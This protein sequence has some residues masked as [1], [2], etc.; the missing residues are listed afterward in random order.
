MDVSW[1]F[2][3]G[4]LSRPLGAAEKQQQ[5]QWYNQAAS[6]TAGPIRSTCWG[7]ELDHGLIRHPHH[8]T[9]SSNLKTIKA[10]YCFMLARRLIA[11]P[12]EA[13]G[14]KKALLHVFPVLQAFN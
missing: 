11:M 10:K 4:S 13:A 12:L 8:I 7:L 5:E 14:T 2:G 3:F 9:E 1:P 6:L